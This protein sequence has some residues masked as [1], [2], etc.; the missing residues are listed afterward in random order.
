VVVSKGILAGYIVSDAACGIPPEC[1]V[2]RLLA[3]K[4]EGRPVGPAFFML[5]RKGRADCRP[6]RRRA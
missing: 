4:E 1:F 5:Q 2:A 6:S 3:A